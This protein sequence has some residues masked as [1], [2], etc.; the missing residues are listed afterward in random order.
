[1]DD[2]AERVA[3][4]IAGR[5]H[6]RLLTGALATIVISLVLLVAVPLIVQ[7]RVSAIWAEVLQLEAAN[8]WVRDAR[9]FQVR[10]MSL[11]R[12]YA[13][14]GDTLLLRVQ[15]ENRAAEI[16]AL[17]EVGALQAGLSPEARRL[18]RTV[19][20]STGRWH[21]AVDLELSGARVPQDPASS[22][23]AFSRAVYE[24]SLDEIEAL[25]TR[26]TRDA[27]DQRLRLAEVERVAMFFQVAM[28][29]LALLASVL[30]FALGRRLR[31]A[32]DEARRL[33]QEAL[34]SAASRNR[35]LRGITHDL[36]NPLGAASLYAQMIESDAHSEGPERQV[37]SAGRIRATIDHVVRL[38][39]ELL[40]LAQA[41]SGMLRLE[42]GRVPLRPI[43]QA[44]DDQLGAEAT[45]HGVS[46]R[47]VPAADATAV[48]GDPM[49]VRQIL[50]NLIGNAITYTPGGG[51]VEICTVPRKHGPGGESG[52]W[53][54]VQVADTGP[55]IPAD[56]VERVFDEFVRL[57]GSARA[58]EG[59]GIGLSISRHLARLMDGEI[60][61][62]SQPGRGSTFS[63]WLPEAEPES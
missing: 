44:L 43:L 47:F 22:E 18:L 42:R 17:E 4:A 39:N 36:K 62:D 46:I 19:E 63:L 12:G 33:H 49:R 45:A 1:M 30:V 10:Q 27:T 3:D 11:L 9:Y 26:I 13:I 52:G 25:R 58:S 16:S 29:L 51:R 2:E 48:V 40:E 57:P 15:R 41:E 54:A 5:H 23:Q 21:R 60:T 55:G 6:R 31:L 50:Q 38:V 8:R 32:L 53:I 56:H 61:L 24:R 35:L 37:Q 28:M 34:R 14:E 20:E 7:R 59:S